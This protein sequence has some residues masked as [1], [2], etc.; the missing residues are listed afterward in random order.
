MLEHALV[1]MMNGYVINK[2]DISPVRENA[3]VGKN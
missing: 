1:I 2:Q 3:N